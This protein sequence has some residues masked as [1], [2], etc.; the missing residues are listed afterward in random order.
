MTERRGLE[1]GKPHEPVDAG[2]RL[3]VVAY[4]EEL[5][6]VQFDEVAGY[7]GLSRSAAIADAMSWWHVRKRDQAVRAFFAQEARRERQL[8]A[9]ERQARQEQLDLEVW[10]RVL[11]RDD[12]EDGDER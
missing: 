5:V 9:A 8:S 2:P 7:L 10:R 6:L 3:R 11:H 4:V 1:L 12:D